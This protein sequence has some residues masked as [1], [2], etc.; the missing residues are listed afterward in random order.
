MPD[1]LELPWARSSQRSAFA[2]RHG[3]L[4]CFTV[5]YIAL[6]FATFC[7]LIMI[8][9]VIPNSYV[10]VIVVS[11][12]FLG[13]NQER[14][15]NIRYERMVL[16]LLGCCFVAIPWRDMV[17][18]RLRMRRSRRVSVSPRVGTVT[19]VGAHAGACAIDEAHP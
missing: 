6:A 13:T 8:H 3:L 4:R 10:E 14:V 16:A 1:M 9:F 5:S 19:L 17:L 18:H 15:F 12:G 2:F 11:E 7:V